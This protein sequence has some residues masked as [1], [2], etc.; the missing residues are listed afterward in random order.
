[1]PG[2]QPVFNVGSHDFGFDGQPLSVEL[3]LPHK[4]EC[5][6]QIYKP[7]S[8]FP[9]EKLFNHFGKSKNH[10]RLKQQCRY[11]IPMSIVFANNDDLQRDSRNYSNCQPCGL[12]VRSSPEI[13]K[14]AAQH[15][16]QGEK[17]IKKA[18][19]VTPKLLQIN[20]Q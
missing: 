1:M 18:F 14:I 17:E 19:F 5:N 13:E 6:S 10:Q 2:L 7:V 11:E 15:C 16:N 20:S 9:R 3:N 12:F 8:G 4:K